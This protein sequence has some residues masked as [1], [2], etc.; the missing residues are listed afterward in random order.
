MPRTKDVSYTD[1]KAPVRK[2]CFVILAKTVF[3]LLDK[4]IYYIN[5]NKDIEI[6]VEINILS[7]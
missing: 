3:K 6:Q 7:P 4:R 5:K 2:Q 1:C